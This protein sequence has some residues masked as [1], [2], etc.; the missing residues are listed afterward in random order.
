MPQFR[1]VQAGAD[2][3]LERRKEG[4]RR[5]F[6]AGDLLASG[7]LCVEDEETTWYG[8]DHLGVAQENDV[9]GCH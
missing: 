7:F 9:A 6:V 3:M 2:V 5:F 1:E 4:A 8:I